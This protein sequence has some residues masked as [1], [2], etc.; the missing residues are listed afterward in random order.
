VVSQQGIIF[1]G[2]RLVGFGLLVGGRGGVGDV[3]AWL[4]SA[5]KRQ[6]DGDGWLGGSAWTLA[7][8]AFH[9]KRGQ[10]NVLQLGR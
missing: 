10:E 5:A 8:G 7:L 2:S 9:P 4:C 6:R 3:L 1:L